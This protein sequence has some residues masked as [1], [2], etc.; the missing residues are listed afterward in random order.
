MFEITGMALDQESIRN[1][2]YTKFSGYTM[3]PLLIAQS[4]L[5]VVVM[6]IGSMIGFIIVKQLFVMDIQ[7][8]HSYRRPRIR[9]KTFCITTWEK[10]DSTIKKHHDRETRSDPFKTVRVANGDGLVDVIIGISLRKDNYDYPDV[11]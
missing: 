4:V 10:L 9:V 5:K 3:D 6:L 2:N 7:S 1:H 11:N 8:L